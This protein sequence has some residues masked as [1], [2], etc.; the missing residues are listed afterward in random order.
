MPLAFQFGLEES[1]V[2]RG[3]ANQQNFFHAQSSYKK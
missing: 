1:A 2:V 3:A